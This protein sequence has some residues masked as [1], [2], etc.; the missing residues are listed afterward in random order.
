MITP[1]DYTNAGKFLYA[2]VAK[3]GNQCSYCRFLDSSDPTKRPFCLLFLE[4]LKVK[5][6]VEDDE[7][8]VI[9]SLPYEAK[10]MR[11]DPCKE[12]IR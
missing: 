10:M 8:D 12:M 2:V 11:C 3:K 5:G 6:E 1:N 7:N 4:A 9:Y